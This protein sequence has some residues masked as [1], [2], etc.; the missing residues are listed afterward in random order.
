MKK[1]LMHKDVPVAEINVMGGKIYSVNRIM[2]QDHMPIGTKTQH[3]NLSS[4]LL[5]SWNNMR[6]LP[7]ERQN[8]EQI[9][10]V[11]GC[12]VSEAKIKSM[13]V[14]LI[15]CYWLKDEGSPLLWDDVNYHTNGFSS[16]LADFLL[17]NNNIKSINYNM[18]DL[19]TDGALK[20]TWL[21]LEGIP[22]LIKFGDLGINSKGKN[23]LSA[24]EVIASKV[25]ELMNIEH[26]LYTPIKIE[27][28]DEIVCACDCFI[29]NSNQEFVNAL[30]LL[31][32]NKNTGGVNLYNIFKNMGMKSD[33]DKMIIFD[34][35]LHN[36]DRHEKNFGIIR[37][38]D[39][40]ETIAFAPLF[41]S[42]S[43]LGWNKENGTLS[44]NDVKPF[45]SDRKTQLRMADIKLCNIPEQEMIKQIIQETYE[46]FEIPENCYKTAYE[47]VDYS[48]HMMLDIQKSWPVSTIEDYER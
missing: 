41:D 18:P 42:G 13:A 39:T 12:T 47:E 23:L 24:N 8:I 28:R 4:Q 3:S 30:Q 38:A 44:I 6:S 25:A 19:T 27:R 35:I 2:N 1:T 33:V 16:D 15:D 5:S 45:S 40:L 46:Q 48:Y 17:W 7:N 32:D 36:M 29:K 43:C 10:K 14:S 21:S 11:L 26:V 37:N 20:K 31:K 9:E 22:T 34:H